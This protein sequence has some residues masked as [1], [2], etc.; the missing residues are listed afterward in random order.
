M[1]CPLEEGAVRSEVDAV[2]QGC[3]ET[4]S[5]WAHPSDAHVDPIGL[6]RL[7]DGTR[8]QTE[9]AQG[10][11]QRPRRACERTSPR[12]PDPDDESRPLLEPPMAADRE[13]R[14]VLCVPA[15]DSDVGFDPVDYA[16][17]PDAER[18]GRP[19]HDRPSCPS[20]SR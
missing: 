4:P 20:G 11:R 13:Q 2:R 9:V 19:A 16:R 1:G 7:K 3:G 14:L 18:H 12:R 17:Q 5:G 8:R 10:G 15:H 6:P